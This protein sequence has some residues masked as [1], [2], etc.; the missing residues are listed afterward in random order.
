MGTRAGANRMKQRAASSLVSNQEELTVGL[1]Q[2]GSQCSSLLGSLTGDPS[3]EIN[4]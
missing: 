4:G 1:F 3:R 2:I